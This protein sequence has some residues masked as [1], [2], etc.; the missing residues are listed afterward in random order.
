MS[1]LFG[2]QRCVSELG[3]TAGCKS[4]DP[5][6]EI[7]LNVRFI[8]EKG[9]SWL[10]PGY[11][12]GDNDWRVR[13]APPLSGRY[14][15]RTESSDA[16]D[17]LLHGQTGSLTAEPYTGAHPLLKHGSLQVSR[18]KRHFEHEDGT[19]FLWLGDTW[20]MG[21]CHRWRWP[22]D[23][24]VMT[25]D[26]QRQ[27]F[28][29]VQIVAGL[30]PDMAAF[31][32]RGANEAGFPW[33]R[34]WARINPAYF[35]MADLRIAWLVRSGIVPCI[36]G[37]WGYYL[38]WLGVEKMKK[39]WRYLIARWG[40]Y[41][42][43]WC[44]AGEAAMPYYITPDFKGDGRWLKTHWTDV[45]R[46]VR[47]LD[48]Y[49]H[50]ITLHSTI[51][52]RATGGWESD[53][54]E[55]IEEPSLVDLALVQGGNSGYQAVGFTV[56]IVADAV[57]R[58]PR[59]PVVQGEAC[60]EGIQSSNGPDIQRF[61]FWS[62]MLSGCA[63]YTYGADG[64]WQI[65]SKTKPYGISPTGVAWGDTPWEEALLAPGGRQI[66]LGKS[67]LARLPWW[68]MEPHQEWIQPAATADQRV[69]P[70]AAGIPRRLRVIFFPQFHN[71]F[72]SKVCGL[73]Q[74]VVYR[75]RYVDPRTVVELEVGHVDT[76]PLACV[77]VGW[78]AFSPELAA[79]MGNPIPSVYTSSPAV[80]FP[81]AEV[82]ADAEGT[83][84][85][86][87]PPIMHDWLLI[88]EACT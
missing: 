32:P 78:P 21:L 34:D 51:T 18:N 52:A 83:W 82:R 75:A 24:Q 16:A 67:V 20:W 13:F 79:A 86:P 74:D 58:E 71:F 88:L 25:A 77:H 85:T 28:N 73:E 87:L 48:P 11:W 81:S 70:Y 33:E 50:P 62:A 4:A 76:D 84:R 2:T 40:A 46:Y 12:A 5:F 68:Q 54:R 14:T 7:E 80:K 26:R 65:N 45:A 63:G 38:P 3:F 36:V 39:H 23:F 30:Y 60:Y 61:C 55:Q 66:A 69:G 31:D 35:D 6:N 44:L 59:I 37:T 56:Q 22:D 27:G 1:S 9:E 15:F 49:H 41:P 64:I 42:V 17:A 47:D 10:V 57:A 8:H 53:S 19:P 43:L 29:V 72:E